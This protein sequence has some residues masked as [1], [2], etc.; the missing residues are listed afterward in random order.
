MNAAQLELDELYRSIP[1]VHCKGKCQAYC[2]PIFMSGEEWKRIKQH[3]P[4]AKLN[5]DS[6]TC[7]LLIEGRCSVYAIR[8]LV[9]RLW[10]AVK[11]MRCQFGCKPDRWVSDEEATRLLR[12][13]DALSRGAVGGPAADLIQLDI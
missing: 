1:N 8:P 10:G 4:V 2:G 11:V 6:L 9:C 5:G 3:G 13:A 7:P 12:R